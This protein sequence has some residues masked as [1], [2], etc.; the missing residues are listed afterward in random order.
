[1]IHPRRI[2][3]PL[4]LIFVASLFFFLTVQPASSFASAES[5]PLA[6][7]W[8]RAQARGSYR[9]ASDVTQ[10][11][12][13]QATLANI[14]STSRAERVYLEGATDLRQETMTLKL[15]SDGWAGGGSTLIPESGIEVQVADGKTQVRR[16]GG[17][18]EEAAG[19]VEG[20]APQGDF[21]SFLSAANA[22]TPHAPETRQGITFTRYTF[23]IDGPAFARYTREQMQRSMHARG[24]L[25]PEMTLATSPYYEGMRGTGELWVGEDGLPVR[26]ILALRFPSQRD[27]QVHAQISTSFSGFAQPQGWAAAIRPAALAKATVAVGTWALSLTLVL[28]GC[29][30]L[31]FFRRKRI[32]Q[33]VLATLL[34]LLM[35]AGPL[36]STERRV[37]FMDTQTARAAQQE[38]DQ[39]AQQAKNDEMESLFSQSAEATFD[40]HADPLATEADS[41]SVQGEEVATLSPAEAAEEARLLAGVDTDG[42]G[43]SDEIEGLLGSSITDKDTDKDG[44]SDYQELY[45]DT[46]LLNDDTDGDQL[47]DFEELKGFLDSSG[48]RWYSDPVKADTNRDG[49]SDQVEMGNTNGDDIPDLIDTDGDGNPDLYDSDNDG[50]G[51]PDRNDLSPFANIGAAAPFSAANPFRLTINDLRPNTPT[52]VDVQLR[53]TDADHLW[54][55]LNVLDWPSDRE[56][57]VQD[58][59]N[60]T[61]ASAVRANPAAGPLAST[62]A[63]EDHGDMRLLPMLEI[64]IRGSNTNLPPMGD[65][66]AYNVIVRDLTSDGLATGSVI[67]KLLYV[68]LSLETNQETGEQV[69]F[70]ARIPYLPGAVWGNAHEMR[71]VWS[72]QALVDFPCDPTDDAAVKQG[73]LPTN[74]SN[75][76]LFEL[77]ASVEA[78][79]AADYPSTAIYQTF[80][81]AGIQLPEAELRVVKAGQRWEI[82]AGLTFADGRPN[83]N[84]TFYIIK[85]EGGKLNVYLVSPG[86]IRNSAQVIQT[87]PEDWVLTG[88]SVREDQGVKMAVIYEDP[89]VDSAINENSELWPLALDLDETFLSGADRNQ[90]NQL[91]ITVNEI[92]RRFDRL[93]NSTVSE[94]ERWGI[95]NILRVERTGLDFPHMDRAVATLTMTTTKTILNDAF[96]PLWS[97]TAPLTPTLMFANEAVYRGIGLDGLRTGSPYIKVDTNL[98]QTVTAVIIDLTP[99]GGTP[100]APETVNSLK[101]SHYCATPPSGVVNDQAAPD[102]RE[103]SGQQ[104]WEEMALR[105]ADVAALPGDSEEIGRG[106]LAFIQLTAMALSKGVSSVVQSNGQLISNPNALSDVN[107]RE[108]LSVAKA[109]TSGFKQLVAVAKFAGLKL[110]QFK[111]TEQGKVSVLKAIG[112]RLIPGSG[113]GKAF[114]DKYG[115]GIVGKVKGKLGST[116]GWVKKGA[117][118][119]AILLVVASVAFG[120][121]APFIFGKGGTASIVSA[122]VS[123]AVTLIFS[124]LQPLVMTWRWATLLISTTVSRLSAL[125]TVLKGSSALLGSVRT[126]AAVGTIIGVLAVWGFFLHSVLDGDVASGKI[127]LGAALAAAIATTIFLVVLAL[128]SLIPGGIILVGILALIDGILALVCAIDG[129]EQKDCFSISGEVIGFIADVFYGYDLMI[130]VADPN[131][132]RRG[133]PKISLKTPTLGYISANTFNLSLPVTTTITHVAPDS[134]AMKVWTG[135]FSADNLRST[136][137]R[138]SLS[139]AGAPFNVDEGQMVN[140]WRNVSLDSYWLNAT[141]YRAH[142]VQTASMDRR[143]AAGVNQR[144]SYYFNMGYSVPVYECFWIIGPICGDGNKTGNKS[145]HVEGPYIDVVPETIDAFAARRET[146][147]GGLRLAWDAQ[148]PVIYDS[149]GDGLVSKAKG[150]IDPNDA[151][152]DSDG[153]GLSDRFE[154]EQR[155]L[156][157]RFS[158][159]SPDTDNDGLFDA[160]EVQFGTDPALADSDGDGLRDSDE[161]YHQLFRYDAALAQVVPVVDGQNIP[162]WTGGWIVNVAP[163]GT[164]DPTFVP[165]A[166]HVSSDPIQ[167]DADGDGIPDAAEFKLGQAGLDPAGNPYHPRVFNTNPLQVFVEADTINRHVLPNQIVPYTTTVVAQTDLGP[168]TV[169]V[170]SPPNPVPWQRYPNLTLANPS[171]TTLPLNLQLAGL[172]NEQKV[173]LRSTASAQTAPVVQGEAPLVNSAGLTLTVD[174]IAPVTTIGLYPVQHFPLP[175]DQNAESVSPTRI[176]GGASDDVGAGVRHV[177]VF[178]N[179]VTGRANGA[180][181]WSYALAVPAVEGVYPLYAW[182]ED[183][184]GNQEIPVS[185]IDVVMDGTAPVITIAAAATGEPLI[186]KRAMDGAWSVR[187]NGLVN[188]PAIGSRPGSGLAPASLEVLMD[189]RSAGPMG[190]Q[191]PSALDVEFGWQL[192]YTLPEAAGDPTDTYTVTVRARDY[193]G[194]LREQ[195][196]LV[197]VKMP[198]VESATAPESLSQTTITEAVKLSGVLTS[199]TGIASAQAAFVPIDQLAVLSDTVVLLPLN[200]SAGSVWFQGGTIQQNDGYC[201]GPSLCP[202]LGLPGIVDRAAQFLGSSRIEVAHKPSLVFDDNTS[203][204]VQA[205][206]RTDLGGGTI[207]SKRVG[208]VGFV[209]RLNEAGNVV[210]NINGVDVVT[211]NNASVTN[212]EWTH[213]AAVFNRERE[214][215]M[216]YIDGFESAYGSFSGSIANDAPLEIGDWSGAPGSGFVGLIDHVIVG[217]KL[218]LATEVTSFSNVAKLAWQDVVITNQQEADGLTTAAWELTVPQDSE[219]FHQAD[220][221][222]VDALDNHH[223]LDSVWR[224]MVDTLAPRIALDSTPSGITFILPDADNP[225]GGDLRYELEYTIAVDD[226]HL[227]LDT[228][229]N[230]CTDSAQPVRGY[231]SAPWKEQILP[232]FTLRNHA[233]ISC[234]NWGLDANASQASA[235]DIY[236]NCR[237]IDNSIPPEEIP[238]EQDAPVIMWPLAGAIVPAVIGAE[239][240]GAGQNSFELNV[241]VSASAVAGLQKIEIFANGD[242]LQT[243]TY[244]QADN[245]TQK[246]ETATLN[247][248]AEGQYELEIRRTDWEGNVLSNAAPPTFSLDTQPPAVALLTDV[249]T[250]ADTYA[251]GSG[252]MRFHGT[253]SDGLGLSTVQIQVDGGPF[254]D[255]TLHSDG[256][257]R[258]ALFLGRD[259]YGKTY[260]ITVRAIDQAGRISTVTK[261]VQVDI[262]GPDEP[263]V[264]NVRIFLPVILHAQ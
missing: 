91:D 206:I 207:L 98:G 230:I 165:V 63:S 260:E 172:A 72:V 104:I 164:P 236:G 222:V 24:E 137:F 176:I 171:T 247:L 135:L 31:V 105:F 202:I 196:A 45:L 75:P 100:L 185:P 56:G 126:V 34:S 124:V 156:G 29:M 61:F 26:Q 51:V 52:F 148:F 192:D 40:P 188:D 57:N 81:G 65:L 47:T 173:A 210:L 215:A 115:K 200:E 145:S 125:G 179:D 223:A 209:L 86:L 92:A 41:A 66:L 149:D 133:Q 212:K 193:V 82:A 163:A 83:P 2:L 74:G 132:V 240:Q 177:D 110:N 217:T 117:L 153:D 235:C 14:G 17:H 111:L 128:I 143:F 4:T 184:L 18:W 116:E 108:Q 36:L 13:P 190:W 123:L 242:L 183:L 221:R 5:D 231:V 96:S 170:T 204:N 89:T 76:F 219:G 129:T 120:I 241:P 251:G 155:E 62:P 77:P 191:P 12:V 168:A 28:A 113:D 227:D 226:L 60:A 195:L 88:L 167:P 205:W 257:W 213:V 71:V 25:P 38:V 85:K 9:F 248:P 21:M 234:R 107:L 121:A 15:W 90:D 50:D 19:L 237:T 97:P 259:A 147:N 186:A 138:Y 69:A 84:P 10:T 208:D 216:I 228:F 139:E 42:D 68:P 102:W 174:S 224:G 254:E 154:L 144:Y 180:E 203:F 6:A 181:S 16:A 220:L 187:L 194:N 198:Y 87:Y 30:A 140:E 114:F 27:E 258:T 201:T 58:W 152:W 136:T 243:L 49:I 130:N 118:G 109:G 182:A 157:L 199:T 22:I 46:E 93:G 232:D 53:P 166:L 127:Q 101:W 23:E 162:V 244:R 7:A 250:E 255:V 43:L 20:F 33:L 178:F 54:Y 67:G 70:R 263:I 218:Y 32:L 112:I 80:A 158:P 134:E 189:G 229:K 79:L 64:S 146:G 99:D 160:Q 252:I 95:E 175:T 35:I 262:T 37:H 197:Q 151:L 256:T 103:C 238:E 94:D 169:T 214:E 39:A 253:A 264:G 239:V 73:C 55:A 78:D 245:A 44:L 233:H 211:T 1:M 3:V 48:R 159:T 8:A 142:A 106:R 161:V 249:L 122:A 59:D 131:L 11:T 246:V 119:L 141:L 225:G 150:G 261:S